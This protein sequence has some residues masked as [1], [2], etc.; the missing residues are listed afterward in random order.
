[1]FHDEGLGA[2]LVKYIEENY[3][4]HPK[5]TI[6]EG[7]TLGFTLMT[8][9]QEY[10]KVIVVGT[11]SK[12]GPVGT[13]SSENSEQVMANSTSTRRTANEVEI[14]MMIE[15]CSFH[16]DMGEVQLITMVPHDI[17]DVKNAMT[18]EA[19]EHMPSL[20][21]E[22]L[23]E[24]KESGIELT[25]KKSDEVSFENIIEAYANPKIADFTDMSKLI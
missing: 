24:L 20:V 3:E 16:E 9:Y 18:P 17:I 23:Y 8:Y 12:I 21:D 6:V 4:E 1:M 19:L 13:I 25:R 22:T 7:G 5:L 11:G 10:D 15:I 2:Y 14:T